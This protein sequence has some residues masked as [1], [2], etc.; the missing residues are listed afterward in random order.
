MV[1]ADLEALGAL[2]RD[3]TGTEGATATDPE[4]W[5]RV[6]AALA[7]GGS[8]SADDARAAEMMR[9]VTERHLVAVG[10]MAWVEPIVDDGSIEPRVTPTALFALARIGRA[11]PHGAVPLLR[12]LADV[13]RG[14]PRWR[15]QSRALACAAAAM[16][17]TSRTG[18]G[19]S[20]TADGMPIPLTD[21]SGSM[22]GTIPGLGRPGAHTIT[23]GLEGGAIALLDV[24]ARYAM[25]WNVPPRTSAPI[26][27]EW[28]G[29]TGPREARSALALVL[30]NRGARVLVR[31]IVEI[32]LP[33]GAELDEPT[34][35]GLASVTAAAP[36]LDGNVLR[37][38]LRPLAPG[39]ALTLP[40]RVRW[41]LGGSFRGLGVAVY[42]DAA[43]G[44]GPPP[45]A[46]LPSRAVEIADTGPEPTPLESDLPGPPEPVPP[47]IVPLPRPL[48]E[49]IR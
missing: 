2:L 46:V 20:I 24:E 30:H 23:A 35:E 21:A 18:T 17:V 7:L 16:L 45:T 4:T 39:A 10:D 5:S 36:A 37:L 43:G 8:E 41:S 26:D 11:D 22:V 32:Q 44:S 33:A 48:S 47:P 3:Q 6:A 31:P 38:E 15:T 13:A 42:D 27:L 40:I 12:A 25:P 29:E 49:V 14:A 28:I 34:R 1:R 19:A 9:R